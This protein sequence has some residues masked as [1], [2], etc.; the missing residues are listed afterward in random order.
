ML[1]TLLGE[2]SFRAGMDRYFAD[3]D[4][5]AATVEDFL[6]AHE[7]TSGRDLSQFA[8]WYSQ[9]GTPRLHV[10]RHWED[11]C[12]RLRIEQTAPSIAGH[13]GPDRKSTRLNSS[14]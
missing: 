10:Q 2:A 11:G 5:R 7:A 12:F 9:A 1:H 13:S 3:N 14:H 8:R 4:G 6:R